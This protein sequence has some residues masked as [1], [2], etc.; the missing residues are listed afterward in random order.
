MR[1]LGILPSTYALLVY[2]DPVNIRRMNTAVRLNE[3]IVEHSH[4]AAL[5]M[6]NL[7]GPPD[8]AGATEE[9]NCIPAPRKRRESGY[10]A[11]SV[12]IYII[13]GC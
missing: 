6:V 13:L 2:R 11:T 9:Q 12:V 10:C 5:V 4:N 8:K 7:P 1:E 3:L